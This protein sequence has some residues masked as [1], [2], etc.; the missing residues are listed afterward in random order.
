VGYVFI[1]VIITAIALAYLWPHIPKT[2]VGWLLLLVLAPPV[3]VLLELLGS[4]TFSDSLVA[5]LF[6]VAGGFSS[7]VRIAYGV[8]VFLLL[9]GAIIFAASQVP[10][11]IR[12]FI[13]NQFR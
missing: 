7:V 12:E 1:S 5:R 8:V 9:A 2:T 3:Y 10:E 13:R 6:G 4:V 11:S